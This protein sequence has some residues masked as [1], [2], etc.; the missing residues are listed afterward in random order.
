M[1]FW[2]VFW[3]KLVHLVH[4]KVGSVSSFYWFDEQ[5]K[6][7]IR[8]WI[9]VLGFSIRTSWLGWL[10]I[11]VL[12]TCILYVFKSLLWYVY[13]NNQWGLRLYILY[14][15]NKKCPWWLCEL[16]AFRLVSILRDFEI[17]FKIQ[18]LK[19]FLYIIWR[20]LVFYSSI[21]YDLFPI[22]VT[23]LSMLFF[24]ISMLLIFL[25]I[26]C[27]FLVCSDEDKLKRLGELMNESH[28]S[29]SVLYE[30]R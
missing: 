21:R 23:Y 15:N 1:N 5:S 30:C 14:E 24:I 4:V 22:L 27:N 18:Y 19:L 25:L 13:E 3:I 10:L 12:N 7:R 9:L 16:D 29:C 17:I 20:C 11:T 28:H 2:L 26:T 6:N 8:V